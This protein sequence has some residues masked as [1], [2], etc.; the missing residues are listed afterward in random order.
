ML[1]GLYPALIARSRIVP[2]SAFPVMIYDA[3]SS[4]WKTFAGVSHWKMLWYNLAVLL[5]ITSS[6]GGMLQACRTQ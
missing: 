2:L 4:D 6:I 3:S 5:A 1:R